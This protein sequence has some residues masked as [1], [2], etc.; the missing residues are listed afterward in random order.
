MVDYLDEGDKVTILGKQ[1]CEDENKPIINVPTIKVK[2][3][4]NDILLKKPSR[5]NSGSSF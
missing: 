2:I 3:D 5:T 4:G 1:K